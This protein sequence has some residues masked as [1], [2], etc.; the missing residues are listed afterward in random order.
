MVEHSA[1]LE[2]RIPSGLDDDFNVYKNTA[3]LD[4]LPR[5]QKQPN[6]SFRQSDKL[7]S[8]STTDF[9]E[10]A[11]LGGTSHVIIFNKT[12]ENPVNVSKF[13]YSSKS[14]TKTSANFYQRHPKA[15]LDKT[16]SLLPNGEYF[17]EKSGADIVPYKFISRPVLKAYPGKD[18]GNLKI[19]TNSRSATTMSSADFFELAPKEDPSPIEGDNNLNS[20]DPQQTNQ[21]SNTSLRSSRIG[22]TSTNNNNSNNSHQY[23]QNSSRVS[24]FSSESNKVL[25]PLTQHSY[26]TSQP[27]WVNKFKIRKAK[28]HVSQI[29]TQKHTPA[30]NYSFSPVPPPSNSAVPPKDDEEEENQN[31]QDEVKSLISEDN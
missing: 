15:K 24:N 1:Y 23:P 2:F 20:N 29:M 7:D 25:Y 30:P 5:K 31:E 3:K 8:T 19:T 22:M 11:N 21:H 26:V 6:R 14:S 12:A 18:P 28:E 27:P 4:Y 16:G 17:G 13:G 9:S 10:S